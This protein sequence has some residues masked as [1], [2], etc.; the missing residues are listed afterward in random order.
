VL[1][2]VEVPF[3]VCRG[4]IFSDVV[5]A[6]NIRADKVKQLIRRE[7]KK[8]IILSLKYLAVSYS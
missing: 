3:I 1:K 4:H 7:V 5:K 2:P 8:K 6:G